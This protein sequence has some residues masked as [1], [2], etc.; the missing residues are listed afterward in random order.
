M[1]VVA[2]PDR[3]PALPAIR[4]RLYLSRRVRIALTI[5]LGLSW[6]TVSVVIDRPWIGDLA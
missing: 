6:A 3:A 2:T 1:A 5:A 4:R